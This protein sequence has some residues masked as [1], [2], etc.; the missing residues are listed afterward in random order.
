MPSDVTVGIP[1]GPRPGHRT[2]LP[3]AL[4]S[5]QQQ[6]LQPAEIIL[7]CDENA[8]GLPALP[9][10]PPCRVYTSPW[11]LGAANGFNHAVGLAHTKYVFLLGSD[12]TLEPGC[13]EACM[14]MAGGSESV[15]V[16]SG[17]RYMSNC[18]TQ[19]LPCGA[20][21]VPVALWKRIGGYPLECIFGAPDHVLLTA[22]LV[23]AHEYGIEIR[24]VEAP[25][26][27]YRTHDD[28]E[29]FHRSEW[30]GVMGQVRDILQETWKPRW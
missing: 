3:E 6:T 17:V 10:Y 21:M 5:C 26:Y 18:E 13:L 30:H 11:K 27:N 25:L 22:L 1:V 19:A 20:M 29:Q 14:H 23:H 24:G 28:T 9:D 16:W 8:N 4:E 12:D 15:I 7:V 2:W